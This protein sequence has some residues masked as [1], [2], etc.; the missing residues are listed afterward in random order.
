MTPLVTVAWLKRTMTTVRGCRSALTS[1][2]M[3]VFL[4]HIA[5]SWTQIKAG[6]IGIVKFEFGD[7][8]FSGDALGRMSDE[9]P[10]G[11]AFFDNPDFVNEFAKRNSVKFSGESGIWFEISLSGTGQ[12]IA[13]VR[14]CQKEQPSV[15][16]E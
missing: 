14:N 13:A 10:G 12:A 15:L 16:S 3:V 11:Y 6:D 8:R 2:G 7:A 4:L 5:W 9:L 1:R